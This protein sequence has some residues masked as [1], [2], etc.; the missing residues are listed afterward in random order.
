MDDALWSRLPVGTRAEV[1]GLIADGRHI[2]AIAV[3]REQAGLPRPELRDCV[4]LL[5]LRARVLRR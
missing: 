2:Q 1:D 5:E 4:D 3:M